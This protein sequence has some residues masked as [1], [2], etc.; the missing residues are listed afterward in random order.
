MNNNEFKVIC[1]KGDGYGWVKG[2]IYEFKNGIIK[3]CKEYEWGSF[4][5]FNEFEQWIRS[6]FT[7]IYFEEFNF[8]VG[9]KAIRKETN[10]EIVIYGYI[11][12]EANKVE[13]VISNSKSKDTL[14]QKVNRY[15]ELLIEGG[16]EYMDETCSFIYPNELAKVDEPSEE[17]QKK[18]EE[19]IVE[20]FFKLREKK[21]EEVERILANNE[22]IDNTIRELEKQKKENNDKIEKMKT[23]YL[24]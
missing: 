23:K 19:Q 12:D 1:T 4:C 18:S 21:M 9:D 11:I 6:N 8:N 16:E 20:E 3:D 10:E 2:E 24:F 13:Y 22:D 17:E 5:D 15:P 14:R 7:D